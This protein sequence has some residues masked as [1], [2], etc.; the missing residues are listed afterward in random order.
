MPLFTALSLHE[1]LLHLGNL[2]LSFCLQFESF[3]RNRRLL[4]RC[5]LFRLLLTLLLP[6]ALVAQ[7]DFRQV[8]N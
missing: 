4:L 2:L 3:A 1:E 8:V 7:L 5:L 6:F